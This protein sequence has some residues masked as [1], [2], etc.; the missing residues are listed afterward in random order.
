MTSLHYEFFAVPYRYSSSQE[1]GGW[2]MVSLPK[3]LSVEMRENFKWRE[4]GWG[5]MKVTA[6]SEE[7][8]SEL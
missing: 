7:H 2:T 3:E 5:R 8:T 1:M 6:R 4:E